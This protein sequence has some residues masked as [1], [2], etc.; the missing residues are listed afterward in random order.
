MTNQPSEAAP[1]AATTRVSMLRIANRW[2]A[3]G[4]INQARDA[5]LR[6][7]AQYPG[8]LEAG[9]AAAKLLEQAQEYE[10]QGQLHLA[11]SLYEQLETRL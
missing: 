3:Q 7:M 1:V 9:E 5:Y 4:Q 8:T 6:L 2:Q 11:L 10:R